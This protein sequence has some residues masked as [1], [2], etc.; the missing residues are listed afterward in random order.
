[1]KKRFTPMQFMNYM[2]KTKENRYVIY[3]GEKVPYSKGFI[4]E[5]TFSIMHDFDVCM[6]IEIDSRKPNEFFICKDTTLEETKE[7]N[8]Q[9]NDE[10]YEYEEA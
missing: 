2:E 8:K 9:L 4:Q 3:N 10:N 5:T 7:I 1:M 6:E